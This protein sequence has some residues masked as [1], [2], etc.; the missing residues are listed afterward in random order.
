MIMSIEIKDKLAKA[1]EIYSQN[2]GF[3]AAI[4]GIPYIGSSID[5]FIGTVGQNIVQG[6]IRNEFSRS[7]RR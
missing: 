2:A 4:C 7:S 6:R 5:A 3:R 1:A